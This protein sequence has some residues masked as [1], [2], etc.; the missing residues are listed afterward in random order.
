MTD[1]NEGGKKT[2]EGGHGNPEKASLS[3]VEKYIK[4]ISYPTNKNDLIKCAKENGAPNDFLNILSQF[5]EEEYHSLIDVANEV[6]N[7]EE[8]VH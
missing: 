2:S 1:T 5:G 3:A 8:T 6:G 4:N 7:I